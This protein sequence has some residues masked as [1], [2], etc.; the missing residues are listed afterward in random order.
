M[1]GSLP[2]AIQGTCAEIGSDRACGTRPSRGQTADATR[3][4]E[5]SRRPWRAPSRIGRMAAMPLPRVLIASAPHADTFGYS[6]PPPGLLRL[7]GELER[8]GLPLRLELDDLAFR[9][10]AD[11]LPGAPPE[12]AADA[13]GDRLR[14]G[15][16]AHLLRNGPPEVLGLS[17]MGANLPI[18]LAVAEQVRA[19]APR[20]RVVLGG[21]GT[22][23][24][25]VALL[26]RFDFVD[27]IV[28]G[29]GERTCPELLAALLAEPAGS[30][31]PTTAD[32]SPIDGLTWRAPDGRVVRN[33]DRALLPD[34]A[35]VADYAWHL[36]PPLEA[37]KRVTGAADGLVPIDSGRGCVYDC[38]FCTIGRSWSR[39]S[40]PLPAAR[41]AEEIAAVGRM[42]AGKQAYLCHDLFGADRKHALA[43]CAELRARR[44]DVP[45]EVRARADHLDG[46]L[47]QAM[48]AAGCYRVLLGIESA[49]GAVRNA[50]QKRM[51]ADFDVL[52][53]VE[54]LLAAGITPI[55][56]L[57][58]GLPGETDVELDAT[59]E[60]CVQ[61]SL[62]GGVNLSLHLVNPQP[63]CGLGEAEGARSRPVEGIA[64]D[65]A[66]GTGHTP[67][68]RALIE[69]HPDLF[70]T[71]ALLTGLP[72]G[73]ARLRELHRFSAELAP[74]LMRLPRAF[75]AVQR[76][77]GRTALELA[78]D[79]LASGLSFEGFALR[80][81]DELVRA[82]LD[83]DQ[84]LLRAAADARPTA[85]DRMR[86][87]GERFRL[88]C[89]PKDLR[90]WLTGERERPATGAPRAV[91]VVG[92]GARVLTLA[93]SS[94][95]E[96]ILDLLGPEGRTLDELEAQPGLAG[97]CSRLAE[98][99]LLLAP[100]SPA[101]QR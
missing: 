89:S 55:L 35:E 58:L 66:L 70:S 87:A 28:R 30:G 27:A 46:E 63:G 43:L 68:E 72:G 17:V 59:L 10:A 21:P 32:L 51:D 40:R 22:T 12:S 94:D 61:S 83:W 6:M 42:P 76:Q 11:E 16:V 65:M 47:I 91:W 80:S 57:I 54:Q 18:A 25:D 60:L 3:G 53:K 9:L 37:Y 26:E 85:D 48:G 38:A 8:C 19:R 95:V 64:P 24:I 84:A 23:G 69:A 5:D 98:L 67:A 44:I 82:A 77:S 15:T 4:R 14:D 90:A 56:S 41:L 31:A 101:E 74:L 75:A 93:V 97:A 73:E 39:R 34:L 33:A 71:F 79:W 50:S 1:L 20:T 92:E 49:D 99:G 81:G 45:W 86:P 62:R 2:S 88:P 13:E 52:G 7:G 78:R 29:E 96:R 36:L 100:R